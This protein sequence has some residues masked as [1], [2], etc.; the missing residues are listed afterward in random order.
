MSM[1]LTPAE[2]EELPDEV[3][4]EVCET[5]RVFAK[6]LVVYENSAYHVL[7]GAVV[8]AR[9]A[10]D[11][12]VLGV[13][14]DEDVYTSDERICNYIEAFHDY[15]PKYIGERDYDMLRKLKAHRDGAGT[16]AK[17]RLVGRNAVLAEANRECCKCGS[18]VWKSEVTGYNF[19][20]FECDED[21]FAFETRE[22]EGLVVGDIVL[23]K[24]AALIPNSVGQ[25]TGF[26][27]DDYPNTQDHYIVDFGNDIGTCTVHRS[28]MTRYCL[29][30]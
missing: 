30:T 21:L 24:S 25:I 14:Y 6:C 1:R 26:A 10:P 17:V 9:Y 23:T 29:G 13:V 3:Q 5:L 16:G 2:I 8:K 15:P 27:D 20:C 19:Q 28:D 4:R 22:V 12:K 11:H 7:T 18:P